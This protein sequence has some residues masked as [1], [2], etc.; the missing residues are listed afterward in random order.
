MKSITD[1]TSKRG[2][3]QINWREEHQQAFEKVIYQLKQ[4]VALHTI[5]FSKDF[6]IYID[7]SQVAIGGCL[8]QWSDGKELPIAFASMKLTESQTKWSP[9]EREAYALIWN[10]NKYRSWIC[11]SNIIVFSDHNPLTYLTEVAPKSAKLTRWALA[12]QEFNLDFRYHPGRKNLVEPTSCPA[13]RR[14][15]R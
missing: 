4:V 15:R 3:N 8:V 14:T 12:L 5:D 13:L 1:L 2:P 10:Q 11:L 9:I 7:A 6:G